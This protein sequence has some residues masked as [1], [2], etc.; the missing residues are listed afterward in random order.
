MA[1]LQ[2]TVV[3]LSLTLCG[4]PV[5]AAPTV[6]FTPG[7][8]YFYKISALQHIDKTADIVTAAAVST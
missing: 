7:V 6:Y 3:I 1:G 8:E 4:L 2:L 5:L